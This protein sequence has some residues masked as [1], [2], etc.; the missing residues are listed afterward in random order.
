MSKKTIT[1]SEYLQLVGL[2]K[3]ADGHYEKIGD[4]EERPDY[5]GV[6]PRIEDVRP[7]AED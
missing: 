6:L 5:V 7:G 2:L 4:I 1:R 3:L